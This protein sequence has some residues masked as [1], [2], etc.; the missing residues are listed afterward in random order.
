L[1]TLSIEFDTSFTAI[2]QISGY[3]LL[4]VG[5]TGPFVSALA[6]K[7][8]KRPV[9]VASSIFGVIGTIIGM[10]ATG[11]S[12]LLASRIVTGFSTSAYE[13]VIISAVGDL[14]FVHQRGVRISL[15]NFML[16]AISNG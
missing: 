9:F 1:V 5:A 3:Y 8:G 14:Y 15:V 7:W 16:A 4:V 10:A 12:S 13:F 11:Y 6:T 2:A